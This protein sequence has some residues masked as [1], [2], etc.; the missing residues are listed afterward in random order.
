[1]ESPVIAL[2]T[3]VTNKI[4][5]LIM[6]VALTGISVMDTGKQDFVS[7]RNP[8]F[9]AVFQENLAVIAIS[10]MDT[11]KRDFNYLLKEKF[12]FVL[13]EMPSISIVL[14]VDVDS[15]PSVVRLKGMRDLK[16]GAMIRGEIAWAG[17]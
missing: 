8:L 3:M 16:T 13:R 4:N 10:M 15:C 2:S 5:D 17:L 11:G 9:L 7:N 6:N 14:D 12:D 1:M